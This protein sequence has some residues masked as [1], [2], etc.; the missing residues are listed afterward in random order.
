MNIIKKNIKD[1]NPAVYNPRKDLQPGDVEY[2]HIKN[3]IE[4]FGYI[5][6]IIYNKK[7]NVIIG[8]HQRFKVLKELGYKEIDCVEVD[9]EEKEEKALNIALNKIGGE[10][11]M[12]ALQVLLSEFDDEIKNQLGFDFEELQDLQLQF[13]QEIEKDI[14][15]DKVPEIPYQPKT[16][17]G[18]IYQ[19]G[20]HRLMIGDSTNIECVNKL[21][22][23]NIADLVVTD[24]PYNVNVS[25]SK[26]DTIKNDNMQDLE[27]Y[28]FLNSA[29][30]CLSDSLKDGGSYYIWCASSEFVNF[31][32]AIKNNNLLFKQEIIW[33]KSQFILGR[34]DYH[35]KHE[36]CL[37]GWKDGASHY[38][39]NDRTQST[40]IDEPVPEF[41]KMKKEELIELLEKIYSYETSVL[42]EKKPTV[43]DLHPTMKPVNLIARLIKNSSKQ[44]EIVLDLFG[45]SGTTLI[46]CEQLNRRCYM[47]E[48]DT[49]YADVIIKR[50]ESLTGQK[51]ILLNGGLEDGKL[52]EQ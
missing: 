50:W 33:N 47:M 15:E 26:G 29:F 40:V 5:D 52:T 48:Y 2:E 25:N 36:P 28:N 19:L 13:E 32:K 12:E 27:F 17:Q 21:M 41:N 37:Y 16:K 9:L 4:K 35:W 39:I 1:L 38:F 3:S 31:I 42:Y 18:Q 20:N 51:S 43:N 44:N 7:N 6:P 22:N 24:P 14:L 23:G 8:G 30:K 45:G 11:D 49:K 10:W 46:A 34:N